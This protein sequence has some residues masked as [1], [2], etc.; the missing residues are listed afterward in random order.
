MTDPK[1][2]TAL[3]RVAAMKSQGIADDQIA[4]AC[5]IELDVLLKIY[6]KQAFKDQLAKLSSEA[7]DK[8]TT[9]NEGWDIVEN[10]GMNKVIEHLQ[11]MPDPEFA[12]RAAAM[13]N[14]A[15]R[16]GRHNN[17]PI[18]AIPNGQVT[19]HLQANFADKM[20]SNFS[21]SERKPEE[22]K[23]KD[24]NFLP[25]KSVQQL[26]GNVVKPNLNHQV[27]QEFSDFLPAMG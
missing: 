6:E 19:I 22:V 12:L 7:F 26:L 16:R 8:H 9:L 4:N 2:Q 24:N 15:Q 5:G 18:N 1:L 25:P 13:A 27:E 23:Q 21:I 17:N 11:K 20:A 14:K 3:E 10:L